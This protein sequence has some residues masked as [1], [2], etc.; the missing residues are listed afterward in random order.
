MRPPFRADHVGSFLR[1][2][3]LIDARARRARGEIDAPELRSVEDEAIRDI[4]RFQEE[5]GLKGITDGEFRRTYFHVDFLTQLG[6]VIEEGGTEVKFHRADGELNYAPP[7]MKVVD[8]VTH[9]RDIQ[10]ADF[11]F[12]Q[13]A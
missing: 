2:K 10:R 1:P 11:E 7:V 4:V 5:L 12:L 6:G 8:R 3:A 9:E 13:S